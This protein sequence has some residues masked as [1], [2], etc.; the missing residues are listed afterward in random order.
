MSSKKAKNNKS[1][2]GI[3]KVEKQPHSARSKK[4]FPIPEKE[5]KKLKQR[6][7]RPLSFSFK[8]VD[9]DHKAFKLGNTDKSWYIDLIERLQEI[10]N[11]T[12]NE[13]VVEKRKYYQVH[14]HTWDEL[15]YK[16][17]FDHDFLEQVECLQFSIDNKS[18]I[19][20]FILGNCF[21]I[22]WFDPDHNLYPVDR[23]GGRSFYDSAEGQYLQIKEKLKFYK[24]RYNRFLN[25]NR[26]LTNNDDVCKLLD[27]LDNSACKIIEEIIDEIG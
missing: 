9:R 6:Q 1:N 24:E 2:L 16:F 26:R 17:E 27:N 3:P 7:Q 8:H 4:G 14:L 13:L 21:Y 25:L 19:H 22:V 18:R 5:L 15:D 10:S 23:Y 20:G 12:R 11:L